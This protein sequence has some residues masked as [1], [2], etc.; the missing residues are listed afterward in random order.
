MLDHQCL[1]PVCFQHSII[2]IYRVCTG[3]MLAWWG[4]LELLILTEEVSYKSNI[5]SKQS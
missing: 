1:R 2:I 4:A 3:R 5:V